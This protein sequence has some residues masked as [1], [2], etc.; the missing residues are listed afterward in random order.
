[1]LIDP[2]TG[3]LSS[4]VITTISVNWVSSAESLHAYYFL[5]GTRTRISVSNS[6]LLGGASL[7]SAVLSADK[8]YASIFSESLRM[9][10]QGRFKL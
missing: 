8:L 3:V 1:M 9:L 2:V 6:L 10:M 5:S 4:N 7:R